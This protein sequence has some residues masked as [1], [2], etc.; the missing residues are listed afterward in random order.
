VVYRPTC[1][2]AYH[3]TEEAIASSMESL[4]SG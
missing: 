3:P 2:Y 4:G 1:H